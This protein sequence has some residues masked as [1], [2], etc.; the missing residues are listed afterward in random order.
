MINSLIKGPISHLLLRK[1]THAA[2]VAHSCADIQAKV[3]ME[4]VS[5]TGMVDMVGSKLT[6]PGL[7]QP[8][9][10]RSAHPDALNQSQTRL[11]DQ[12]LYLSAQR[13]ESGQV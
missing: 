7:L 13:G 8:G 1:P 6:H 11:F 9:T 2:F 4:H 3:P 5:G 10:S 12:S